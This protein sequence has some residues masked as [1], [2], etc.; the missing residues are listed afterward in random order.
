LPSS[1]NKTGMLS[2]T[3]ETFDVSKEKSMHKSLLR[4]TFAFCVAFLFFAA[5][6]NPTH[7]QVSVGPQDVMGAV[8]D[9]V[10]VAIEAGDLSESNITSYQFT[11]TY[12]SSVVEVLDVQ[13]S[14]TLSSDGLLQSNTSVPGETRVA[15]ASDTVLGGP[16]TLVEFQAVL[17]SAGTTSIALDDA[18]FFDQDGQEVEA[19][20]T[21][22]TVESSVAVT[23]PDRQILRTTDSLQLPIQVGDLT[24]SNASSYQFTLTFNPDV[25]NITDVLTAGT[26]SEGGSVEFNQTAPGE[27]KVAFA[28]DMTLEG[29]GTLLR[30][31]ATTGNVGDSPLSVGDSFR[32]FAQDG[33]A[34]PTMA[35][36]GNVAVTEV[37]RA[38]FIHN[39]ADP[40]ASAVDIY[41]GS[42]LVL[43]DFEFRTATPFIDVPADVEINV[44]VAPGSSTSASDTLASFP[45]TLTPD[46]SHTVVANGVLNPANFAPNPDGEPTGFRFLVDANAQEEATSADSVDVRAVH[47]ATDAPTVDI[48]VNGTTLFDDVVYGD[49]SGYINAP[50]ASLRLVVTPGNSDAA[51]AAFQA[52]LSGLAGQAATVLASGFL[53]PAA[54]QDGAAFGLIAV[55]PD[56]TVVAFPAN[57]P[58]TF[59]T[60][61]T[62]QTVQPAST[63]EAQVEAED[64]DGDAVTFSLTEAPDNASI[65]STSG[66]FSFTPTPSQAGNTF[67]I[68]V[69]VSD[70]VATADTSFAVT[71]GEI[72]RGPIAVDINLAFGDAT[73]QRN[74]RLAGLPGQVDLPINNTLSGESGEFNDWRV[75]W[76]NGSSTTQDGLVEFDGSSQFNFQPG[77]G[78]WV[79][80]KNNWVV[81]QEFQPVPLDDAANA[82]VSL[83]DGWNIISNPLGKD[84][85][86]SAV[87]AVNDVS[88][89]LWSFTGSFN[90]TSSFASAQSGQAFYFLNEAGLDQ[91]QV[92]FFDA[93]PSSVAKSEEEA[94]IVQL[95]AMIDSKP[96]SSVWVGMQPNAKEGRDAFDHF[97][98][99]GY[100]TDATLSVS[101]DKITS[102]YSLASDVRPASAEG[103]TYDLVLEAKPGT[104]VNLQAKGLSGLSPDQ[105]VRL[106]SKESGQS[107]DLRT[108]PVAQVTPTSERA[109]FALL[110][111][112]SAY[113][114]QKQSE[115]VPKKLQLR[116]NYPNPF[117][118]Q[119]TV[120]YTLPEQT[121]V[122]VEVYDILG[123]RI[124]TLLDGKTQRAGVHTLQWNAQNDLGRPVASGVY[125]TRL[126]AGDQ[127]RTIKMVVIK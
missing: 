72:D 8:G 74:Y 127:T 38:Q 42:Q 73:Q 80:S 23:L 108:S 94:R 86:W 70:G 102:R 119:T 106:Y 105:E 21:P 24:G 82:S 103:H 95:T 2:V 26:L 13:S 89:P 41:F 87:Q 45:L 7:A 55:L 107:F 43:D 120:E 4:A 92:P 1:I 63:V 10:T 46:Q 56:G 30:F 60:V 112:T 126:Q 50:P 32:L 90:Q 6:L 58:P 5:H 75:F 27:V 62:D 98:P 101:N 54:N 61:P 57:Q 71:V 123:R 85:S 83:H 14:N 97:S 47:G 78:F 20:V 29:P 96:A 66:L 84:I 76:D 28:S 48:G 9:T 40:A 37:A 53:D 100:F 19:D 67:N 36:E 52:D 122:K 12:D 11:A 69:Q 39:A 124:R 25:L 115:L 93:T 91:L 17:R 31:Q 111:G 59:T 104:R 77:R 110:V 113:V 3:T 116:Q 18:R 49:I 64:P 117:R 114:D 51:V 68:G 118:G 99:P 79:L 15:F 88:Q 22:G 125:L 121:E 109:E 34:I 44:G 81:Q 16:G 65:D 33:G 35:T